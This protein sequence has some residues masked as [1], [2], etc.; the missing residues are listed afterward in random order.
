MEGLPTPRITETKNVKQT[1]VEKVL[2]MVQL[3]GLWRSK[4]AIK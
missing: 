1:D 2:K 3:V 4:E